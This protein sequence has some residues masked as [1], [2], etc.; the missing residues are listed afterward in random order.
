MAR[1]EVPSH[2]TPTSDPLP[3]WRGDE[4]RR[5]VEPWPEPARQMAGVGE[6][7]IAAPDSRD[8]PAGSAEHE[9]RFFPVVE[10]TRF[11]RG[12]RPAAA[13]PT[14]IVPPRESVPRVGSG[15]PVPTSSCRGKVHRDVG[16][17]APA[18]RRT[19]RQ[20]LLTVSPPARLPRLW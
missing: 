1:F 15:E 17:S 18:T 2:K 12:A 8:P 13:T 10:R 19:R 16:G 4:Q 7:G 9:D 5:L 3:A 14:S 20:K 11:P 6:P